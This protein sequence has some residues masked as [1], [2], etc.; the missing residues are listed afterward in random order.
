MDVVKKR[1]DRV[2]LDDVDYGALTLTSLTLPAFV[3]V[4]EGF[5]LTATDDSSLA[6]TVD[7]KLSS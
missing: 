2:T 4:L 7:D 5:W 1:V 6:S 3:I